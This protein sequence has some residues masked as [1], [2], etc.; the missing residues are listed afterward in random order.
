MTLNFRILG[1]IKKEFQNEMGGHSP[2]M[3]N[4]DTE[5]TFGTQIK[6]IFNEM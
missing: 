3:M 2:L 4:E 1:N 5:F 6:Q